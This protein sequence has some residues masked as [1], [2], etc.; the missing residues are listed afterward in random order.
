MNWN[1]GC[2]YPMVTKRER[3]SGLLKFPNRIQEILE[4]SYQK[5]INLSVKLRLGLEQDR[6]V[7]SIIPILKK[8][9]VSQVI[10]HPRVGKQL[11]KG[12]VNIQRFREMFEVYGS[13]IAYNG[14]ICTHSDFRSL[15]ENFSDLNHLMIGR[16]V[17][18]DY[19]LPQKI[20]EL[21]LPSE[22]ERKDQLEKMHRDIYST[23]ESYLQ[24]ETQIMHKMK[25]FWEYFSHHFENDK[26]VFKAIKKAVGIKKY[27]QAVSFA[28]SQK[29]K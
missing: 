13:Y 21:S 6:E 16:G 29:L 18:M 17:L 12:A 10:L 24:G 4:V 8:F 27:E 1:L 26:K 23:Y 7:D 22:N 25:P 20:K 15:K 3:G 9:G 14:D 19:W 2:P 28:F 5:K 11:Y